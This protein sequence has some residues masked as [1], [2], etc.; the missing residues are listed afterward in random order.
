MAAVPVGPEEEFSMS[1]KM[2]RA[3]SILA[4]V[5]LTVTGA[6]HASGRPSEETSGLAATWE[7]IAGWLRSVP[8]LSGMLGKAGSSMDTNGTQLKAGSQMD[9]N[10]LTSDEGSQM[11]PNGR[12]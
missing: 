4:L 7:R 9:P 3:L 2:L 8:G 1:R 12:K 11:D 10:G 5:T 6:A